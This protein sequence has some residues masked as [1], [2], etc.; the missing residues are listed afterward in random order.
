MSRGI[1]LARAADRAAMGCRAILEAVFLL[2]AADLEIRPEA[3]KFVADLVEDASVF[4]SLVL[5]AADG[6]GHDEVQR[7]LVAK[8]RATA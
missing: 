7:R 1:I 2:E 5:D 8:W 4:A 3:E 6:Y